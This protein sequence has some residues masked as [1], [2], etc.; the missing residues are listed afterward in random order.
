LWKN[1]RIIS[2]EQSKLIKDLADGESPYIV[3]MVGDHKIGVKEIKKPFLVAL[4]DAQKF[5][6]L[7]CF[8]QRS[9]AG[10]AQNCSLR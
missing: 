5:F 7:C 10:D 2:A 3:V 4:A 8:A 9:H 1:K 6:F